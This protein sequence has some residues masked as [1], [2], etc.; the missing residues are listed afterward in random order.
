MILYLFISNT[1]YT[2][3]LSEIRRLKPFEW[4]AGISVGSNFSSTTSTRPTT[5]PFGYYINA[6]ASMSIY[7]V[8][9]PI[10]FS[11]RN[12][13]FNY[14]KPYFRL[15]ISPSYK[16]ARIYAGQ[17]SLSFSPY[18]LAG[19]TFTGGGISLTPGKFRLTVMAGNLQNPRAILDSIQGRPTFI[20]PYKRS[21]M[22]VKL[23]VGSNSKNIDLILFKGKDYADHQQISDST[24]F[25]PAENL[26]V[27]IQSKLSFF[28]NLIQFQVNSAASAFTNNRNADELEVGAKEQKYYD[29]AKK[30]TSVNNSTRLN[31]AGDASLN[32]NLNHFRFGGK[33]QYIDPTYSSLGAFYFQDDNENYTINAGT[34]FWKGK[35]NIDGSYGLQRNNVRGHRSI[36]SLQ[37]IYDVSTNWSLTNWFGFNGQYSNY[38]F[39]QESGLLVIN[40]SLRYGQVTATS[41]ISP[42]FTFAGKVF[43]HNINISYSD[44]NVKDLSLDPLSGQDA[45]IGSGNINYSISNK[46]KAYSINTSLQYLRSM[47]ADV[48]STRYGIYLSGQ[49]SLN[50][51]AVRIRG[52]VNYSKN[53]LEA[54]ADGNQYGMNT[55]LTLV[56]NKKYNLGFNINYVNRN[57]VL[58]RSYAEWRGNTSLNIQLK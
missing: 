37:K 52:Q 3:D 12:Q 21:A 53:Y 2:Q 8:A 7:G 39:N 26:V 5:S 46:A 29:L 28:K 38:N 25:K 6:N 49:K 17:N 50:K 48:Q 45:K 47:Y 32:F 36:Q 31:L 44:Q 40:D 24:P 13:Q 22:G 1:G 19:V 23:G 10:S 16:W 42:Y 9:I 55:G 11:Y 57:A 35:I 20:N 14:S 30:L 27:G 43:R 51:N 58:G 15:G 33:Y 54:E 34:D 18:T 41:S 4:R 56:I